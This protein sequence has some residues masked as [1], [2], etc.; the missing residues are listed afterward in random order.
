MI[1]QNGNADESVYF[2]LSDTE[3]D[4][5]ALCTDL[6]QPIATQM[7]GG[8]EMFGSTMQYTVNQ[9]LVRTCAASTRSSDPQRDSCARLVFG[10]GRFKRPII[11]I[12]RSADAMAQDQNRIYVSYQAKFPGFELDDF[13]G[14]IMRSADGSLILEPERDRRRCSEP[15]QC[16]IGPKFAEDRRSRSIFRKYGYS[17]EPDNSNSTVS[18]IEVPVGGSLAPGLVASAL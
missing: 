18:S 3:A 12:W 13:C 9:E 8:P 11:T 6:G 17:I 14:S 2:H 7:C 1:H 16:Y 4:A 10:A 15:C 5:R